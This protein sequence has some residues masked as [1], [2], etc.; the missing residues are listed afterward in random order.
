MPT[1]KH[2]KKHKQ[3]VKQ[4]RNEIAQQ[5]NAYNKQ[6]QKY[7]KQV[8]E[9]NKLYEEHISKGGKPEEF[10]PLQELIKGIPTAEKVT[11]SDTEIAKQAVEAENVKNEEI[12]E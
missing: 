9:L 5:R 12:T 8:Q 10:Q 6:M 1:S 2:R 11:E 7:E 3:K 4:R